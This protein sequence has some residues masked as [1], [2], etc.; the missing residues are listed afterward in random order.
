MGA[1]P[2]DRRA[3]VVAQDTLTAHTYR[4]YFDPDRVLAAG[5]GLFAPRT[6]RGSFSTQRWPW[7]AATHGIRRF[8][9]QMF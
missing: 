6:W 3:L 5:H 2:E 1:L 4:H 8:S 9:D 7:L